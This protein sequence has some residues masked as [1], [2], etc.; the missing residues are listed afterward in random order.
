VSTSEPQDSDVRDAI[1]AI[2]GSGLR[3]EWPATD[4]VVELGKRGQ[5]P[6]GTSGDSKVRQAL[7]ELTRQG[8]LEPVRL[9]IYKLGPNAAS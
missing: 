3:T 7:G 2:V 6:P 5:M 4:I 9:G 1:V 8:A